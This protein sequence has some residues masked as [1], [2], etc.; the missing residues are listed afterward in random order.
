MSEGFRPQPGRPGVKRHEALHC[1]ACGYQIDAAS[2]LDSSDRT[3]SDG[4]WA[5]CFRCGE[6]QVYVVGPLGVALRTAT[7]EELAKFSRQPENAKMVRD[8]HRFWT[9]QREGQ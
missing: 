5:V 1:G 9:T 7:T 8:L 2:T 4:D 3:P 6:V